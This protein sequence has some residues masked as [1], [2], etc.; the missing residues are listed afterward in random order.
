[1]ITGTL[2]TS[3]KEVEDLIETNGG[4]A[5]SSVS[6]STDYLVAGEAPGSKL[7]KAKKVGVK[8]ITYDELVK[9]IEKLRG[10]PR[11]F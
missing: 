10:Q 8:T 1:V 11:L 7:E 3:R 9:R 5:V 4:H 2:P 6:A